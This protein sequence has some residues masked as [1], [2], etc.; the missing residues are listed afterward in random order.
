MEP[1]TSPGFSDLTYICDETNECKNTEMPPYS[2]LHCTGISSCQGAEITI[3]SQGRLVCDNEKACK[4]TTITCEGHCIIT[5]AGEDGCKNMDLHCLSGEC[6]YDCDD[7]DNVCKNLDI[8]SGIW[9][10]TE[11][12]NC[13][14][15][16]NFEDLPEDW[17]SQLDEYGICGIAD[18]VL[19]GPSYDCTFTA[20][21]SGYC[22]ELD[23]DNQC[24]AFQLVTGTQKNL[25]FS[26][27][28][29]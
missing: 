6:Y 28:K 11:F 21:E 8:K 23:S 24:N 16:V 29:N 5:C 12:V 1:G 10:P 7:H 19:R 13:E 17:C 14:G 18:G 9:F 27:L 26:V 25:N 20:R 2:E 4:G 15:Y 22:K 3:L